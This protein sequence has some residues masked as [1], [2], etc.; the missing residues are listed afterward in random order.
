MLR[1]FRGVEVPGL[2]FDAT[3]HHVI[4]G[5]GEHICFVNDQK[6]VTYAEF[7]SHTA[8][9]AG[10]M[11]TLG[12]TRESV[13]LNLA[14]QWERLSVLVA[15]LRL[16]L[17]PNEDSAV[18]FSDE[19]AQLHLP[20]DIIDLVTII[21][22]GRVDPEPAPATPDEHLLEQL[23]PQDRQWVSTLL[24]GETITTG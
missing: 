13:N 10:G 12:L 16:G 3:D 5:K 24:A 1:S 4:F 19:P 7:L 8:A 20:T 15:L 14:N 2:A 11:R 18:V 22:I 21:Q 6:S 17:V 23:T 9:I